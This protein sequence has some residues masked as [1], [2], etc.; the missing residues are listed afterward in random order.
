MSQKQT[1]LDNLQTHLESLSSVIRVFQSRQGAL[2]IRPSESPVV[3]IIDEGIGAMNVEDETGTRWL[4]EITLR[5]H[6]SRQ[7]SVSHGAHLYTAVEE[8]VASLASDPILGAMSLV[9]VDGNEIDRGETIYLYDLSI[10]MQHH[11]SKGNSAI[12]VGSQSGVFYTART[13]ML[14]ELEALKTSISGDAIKFSNVYTQHATSNLLLNAVSF[15]II[16]SNYEELIKESSRDVVVVRTSF[17]VRAH[18]G[19]TGRG[20]R[21]D[22]SLILLDKIQNHF[23]TNRDLD[24]DSDNIRFAG[25]SGAEASVEFD[26]SATTGA[27]IEIEIRS[28]QEYTQA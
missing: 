4:S 11:E 3:E 20:V 6:A 25:S 1:I 27:R 10:Q 28:A 21:S 9:I 24:S 18:T 8:I 26:D 15:E 5:V 16:N 12:A 23:A 13:K 17:E 22:W 2:S 19:Y 7:K 14:T